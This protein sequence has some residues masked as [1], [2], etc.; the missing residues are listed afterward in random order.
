MMTT[1]AAASCELCTP[2]APARMEKCMCQVIQVNLQKLNAEGYKIS[3]DGGTN[4]L[5]RY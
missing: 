5:D 3:D 2:P 1:A 4:D